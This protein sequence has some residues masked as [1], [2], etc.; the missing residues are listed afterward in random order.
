MTTKEIA[1]RLVAYCR[2]QD[3]SGAQRE[4]YSADA[5]SVEPHET[6][7]FAKETKGLSAILEKGKK[8]DAMVETMHS[9]AVSEPVVANNSFACVMSMDVT[10]KGHGRMQMS[11]LC[12]Y[13]VKDGKI[14]R[15][16]FHL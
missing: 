16:E 7:A 2:K 1:T 5:L 14:V 10:M 8:F 3:W 4:L 9:L 15:E 12:V 13:D 11:E 6:P